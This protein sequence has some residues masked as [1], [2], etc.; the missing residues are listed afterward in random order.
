M[1]YERFYNPKGIQNIEH[2]DWDIDYN[3]EVLK[4]AEVND[5]HVGQS[6]EKEPAKKQV[7]AFCGGDKFELAQ[8][9]YYTAVRCPTCQYEYRVH[10]G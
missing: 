4:D 10:E 2:D 1:I 5:F 7:C 6:Y 3:Y 9:N 8:G